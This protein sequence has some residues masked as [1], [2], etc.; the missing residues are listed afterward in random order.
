MFKMKT[1]NMKI[2]ASFL[3]II[4]ISSLIMA[5]AQAPDILYYKGKKHYIHTN[6]LEDLFYKR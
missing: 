2:A 4:I 1:I 3:L 6:P 5:T